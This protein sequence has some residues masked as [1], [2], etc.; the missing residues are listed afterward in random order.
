[1]IGTL[2]QTK[3][4]DDDEEGDS[5]KPASAVKIPLAGT[6]EWAY[7]VI[8]KNNAGLGF[9]GLSLQPPP[10]GLYAPGTANPFAAPAPAPAPGLHMNHAK[11]S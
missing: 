5:K 1:M 11:P 4:K 9:A 2:V 6:E 10:G 7:R 3:K 8:P